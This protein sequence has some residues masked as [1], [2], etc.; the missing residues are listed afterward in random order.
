MV[1]LPPVLPLSV[2]SLIYQMSTTT[3]LQF[4]IINLKQGM[5]LFIV[6]GAVQVLVV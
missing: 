6:M 1:Q 4:P 3:P 2:R 5:S